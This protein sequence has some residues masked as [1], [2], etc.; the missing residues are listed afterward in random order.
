MAG[1]S[2]IS[3]DPR[4]KAA[5][6]EAIASGATIEEIAA[7]VQAS[8]ISRSAV[9]RYAKKYRPLVE[10]VMHTRAVAR[11]LREHLPD[12][13]S[14]LM[15]LAIHKATMQ[16]LRTL[17]D[18]EQSED[19]PSPK[20]VGLITRSVRAA[21]AAQR[22]KALYDKLIRDH[23]VAEAAASACDAA[24]QFGASDEQIDIIRRK[25]LGMD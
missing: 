21:G 16:A 2:S 6:D 13:D 8:G 10:E 18:M 20:D 15:D 5:V 14:S 4:I 22:E 17:N 25:I 24:R 1:R 23:A 19:A 11:V 12:G 3:R 9:G 7:A